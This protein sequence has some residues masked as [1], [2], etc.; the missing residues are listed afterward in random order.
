MKKKRKIF[1]N[2]SKG[3]WVIGGSTHEMVTKEEKWKNLL[4]LVM[5]LKENFFQKVKKEYSCCKFWNSH[6]ALH[7]QSESDII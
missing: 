4:T 7:M 5:E 6:A 1:E 3:Y 2:N